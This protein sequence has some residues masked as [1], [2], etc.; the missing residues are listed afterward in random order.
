MATLVSDCEH[1]ACA[2]APVA[3]SSLPGL[4][5]WLDEGTDTHGE[6]YVEM[7]R[8]LV[9]YFD[10]RNRLAPDALADETFRRISSALEHGA[11]IQA[12]PRARYCYIVATRV[13][14]ED[15]ER[16]RLQNQGVPRPVVAAPPAR[17][18]R[19]AQRLQSPHES[20]DVD[21][22]LLQ[23]PA[24]GR[25][26]VVEYYRDAR[27]ANR[28]HRHAMARR[29]RITPAALGIRA[30]RIRDALMAWAMSAGATRRP[31]AE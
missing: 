25:Q 19:P 31:T 18:T 16:E 11:T 26:L 5:Q 13:L 15:V 3:S 4:I 23:L 6:R 17:G 7:R 28:E 24:E 12:M 21:R 8:R 27:S 30:F 22:S 20:D 29:M 10:R 14:T 1:D 9:G 2:V